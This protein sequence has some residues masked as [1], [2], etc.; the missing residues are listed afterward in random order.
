[1]NDWIVANINNS[2]FTVSDFHDIADMDTNNTQMLS[3]E[4]YLK[5][6]YIKNNPLFQIDGKFSEDLFNKYYQDKLSTFNEFQKGQYPKGPALD[7]FDT[8]RTRDSKVKDIK[9]DI[10]RILANPD[11]QQIGIEGVNIW[12]DPEK[13]KSELAQMSKVFDY[14][15]GEFRDYS[16]ND[17]ALFNGKHDYGIGWLS[18]LFNDPLVMAQYEEDGTHIDP[19]TGQ[20]V[21]HHKGD[22]K[23]NDQGTYYYETLGGRTP[24][25]KRVLSMMDTITI[26]GQGINKYD[27]FDSDDIEKSVPKV[28]AS[29]VVSLLP[30]F[31]GGPVATAYSIGLI[32]KEFSK[33]LPMLYGVV[34]ALGDGQDN[35]K[36]LNS[37]AAI[38]EKF[39][40]GT[41]DYAK[42]HSFSMEN[43]GNMI[44]DV[45]LQW[46]QQKY[47]AKTFNELQNGK[48]YIKEATE[49]AHNL[50]NA[51]KATMGAQ[52]A[53]D[54]ANWMNSNLGKAALKK[55]LPDAEK[56]AV[57][58][59]RLGRDASLAY[60]AI[61]SNTDV[62]NDMLEAGATK[63]EA[64][65]V[66]LGSTIGMFAVD[67]TGL[68]EVFFDDATEE[69]VKQARRVIKNEF[70]EAAK[71]A[72]KEVKKEKTPARKYMRLIKDAAEKSKKVLD[73][74]SEAIKYHS[75]NLSQKMIGEGLEEIAE[76][77]VADTA[78]SIYEI[79]GRLGADTSVKDV[80][81]WQNTLERYSMNF[82]GGALGGGVF[83]G[84]EVWD[85]GTFRVDHNDEELLT[86]IR[87]GH[88][89][90]LRDALNDLKE[91]GK[92]GSTTIS[93][94]D[95]EEDK[96][97][98]KVFITAK[99]REESQNDVLA[100][101]IDDKITALD[102]L[103]NNNQIN[104]DDEELFKR[105]VLGE[106]RF[107]RYQDIS[108]LTN[109]YQDF[110][111][112]MMEVAE[113]SA[114]YN[115]AAHSIDGSVDGKP[116][117]GDQNPLNGEPEEVKIIRANRVK[118]AADKLQRALDKKNAF[119]SGDTSLDY[120]R[121]LAFFMD[122]NLHAPFL[123][124]DDNQ[125]LAEEMGDKTFD[126]YTQDELLDLYGRVQKKKENILKTR[127]TD[128]WE[129]YKAI[130]KMLAPKIAST[131]A[132][133]D[134]H[135]QWHQQMQRILKGG[136]LDINKLIESK[137][138]FNDRMD[139]D[140][141][142]DYEFRETILEGETQEDFKLRKANR[143]MKIDEY[144]DA[145]DK[146][147]VDNL[148]NA[149]SSVDYKIDPLTYDLLFGANPSIDRKTG[150]VIGYAPIITRTKDVMKDKFEKY[151][152][153]HIQVKEALSGLKT[154]L[155]NLQ[156]I[157]KLAQEQENAR[158]NN[159][160]REQLKS[161][162]EDFGDV[163]VLTDFGD[164]VALKDIISAIDGTEVEGSQYDSAPTIG[165]I[166]DGI[167]IPLKVGSID[168]NAT[169]EE[170]AVEQEKVNKNIELANK[171]N[172]FVNNGIL[173]RDFSLKGV[174]ADDN[175]VELNE[176][177]AFDQY[178]QSLF[179][180]IKN[181][182][183]NAV[184]EIKANPFFQL[185]ET[186]KSEVKNPIVELTK[187]LAG[188]VL[189][190]VTLPKVQDILDKLQDDF[191]EVEDVSSITLDDVQLKAFE[192][193]RDALKLVQTYLYAA[194]A[195]PTEIIPIGHNKIFNE[196]AKNHTD[197]VQKWQ[198]LPEV[199]NDYATMYLQ[200]I[201]QY[202]NR[203]QT[204][205]D[206]SNNNAIN[207][208][209]QFIKSDIAFTKSLW[210]SIQ[211][212]GKKAF[213]FNIGDDR[214]NLLEGIDKVPTDQ[215]GK[216]GGAL[217][218]FEAERLLY[219]NFQNA[220]AKSGLS[221]TEFLEESKILD[222]LISTNL[223]DQGIAKINA[224]MQANT[225]SNFDLIKYFAMT[226]ALDPVEFN[227][228]LK[229]RIKNNKNIAPITAQEYG[230]KLIM[231]GREKIFRDI[232][233]YAYKKSGDNRYAALA[234][235]IITGAAGVGKTQVVAKVAKEGLEPNEIIALGPTLKQGKALSES[236]SIANYQTVDA[237][238]KSIL[239]DDVFAN[240]QNAIK[241]D[242]KSDL[243]T[244]K[245]VNGHSRSTINIDSEGDLVRIEEGKA[246][247]K[248]K[249]NKLIN[250]P[251]LLVIDEAT[252]I[253]TP[254]A[255]ILDLYM[256]QNG[257][258]L[259][260][261]GDKKQRGF[262]NDKK[263]VGIGNIEEHNIFA[264]RA[265][266]LDV[267][268][269]DNNIQKQ[270]NLNNVKAIVETINKYYEDPNISEEEYISKMPEIRNLLS[271]LNFKV[272]NKDEIN[273][274]LIVPKLDE[275]TINKIKVKAGNIGYIG[276]KNS[277]T[278]Q[279]LINAGLQDGRDFDQV[280]MEEMQGQEYD[281]V[282][283]D[284]DMTIPKNNDS[285]FR[286]WIQ[287][288][289]T[290]M[291]RGKEA[292]IFIDRGLSAA[293]GANQISEYKAKAPSLNDATGGKS[294]VDVLRENKA[295]LL[296]QFDLS[297]IELIKPKK[298]KVEKALDDEVSIKEDID[299]DPDK[300]GD[301]VDSDG[302]TAKENI[303]E[304][305]NEDI[306]KDATVEELQQS[307]EA[308]MFSVPSF[309]NAMYLSI[310]EEDAEEI[311]TKDDGTEK[312]YKGKKWIIEKPTEGPL[313]N[314]QGL[315]DSDI[316]EAFWYKS[317]TE[318]SKMELQKRLY[319]IRSAA[320][321]EH[322]YEDITKVNPNVADLFTKEAWDSRKVKLEIREAKEMMPIY[323]QMQEIGQDYK[324]HSGENRVMANLVLELKDRN[325]RTVL[326]DL[327]AVNNPQTLNDN[328][329]IILE[330]LRVKKDNATNQEEKSKLT[331]IMTNIAQDGKDYEKIYDQW[332][333]Q[334]DDN[335][336]KPLLIDVGDALDYHKITWFTRRK[337]YGL[338][339]G[340]E[341]DPRFIGHPDLKN[342][343]SSQSFERLHPN[344]VISD[345]YTYASKE[346]LLKDI[347]PSVRGKAVV[348][349]SSDT[350]LSKDEL[351]REY[352][353]QKNHPYEKTPRVRMLVLDNYGMSFSQLM[354]SNAFK[355]SKGDRKP[356]RQNLKGIQMFTSLWNWRAALSKFNK[357]VEKFKSDNEYSNEDIKKI[358]EAAYDVY[359]IENGGGTPDLD[360][361]AA[362]H[363]IKK[364][365]LENLKKFNDETLKDIPIFRLGHIEDDLGFHIQQFDVGGSTAYGAKLG[366][367][368]K[369]HAQANLVSITPQ[370]A[371]NFYNIVNDIMKA[372]VPGRPSSLE[373]Q[374][375][376]EV[377]KD[378]GTTERVPFGEEEFL[379]FKDAGHRRSLSR[380]LHYDKYNGLTIKDADGNN[381]V[382]TGKDMW[383]FVP[384]FL[385]HIARKFTLL[386]NDYHGRDLE[387][388]NV[389]ALVDGKSEGEV[390]ASL[391]IGKWIGN[392]WIKE[393]K[394]E[395]GKRHYDRT[396]LNMF[397]LMFHGTVENIHGFKIK[398]TLDEDNNPIEELELGT[399]GKPIKTK[400]QK[401]TGVMFKDGFF[402]DPDA[403]RKL[404][405]SGT[406]YD[407]IPIRD[408]DKKI[409]FMRIG[410]NKA[411]F[412]LNVEP[413]ASGIAMK[414]EKL[415]ELFLNSASPKTI[416]ETSETD[417]TNPKETEEEKFIK[418]HSATTVEIMQR[419][420][421]RTDLPIITAN[422]N[423]AVDYY[424]HLFGSTVQS[425]AA[426]IAEDGF[427]TIVY[428]EETPNHDIIPYTMQQYLE[429]ALKLDI[430]STEPCNSTIKDGEIIVNDKYHLVN[431]KL[432]AIESKSDDE[433]L[434][435]II[436]GKK[437]PFF[438][439]EEK[440]IIIDYINDPDNYLFG[441]KNDD[442]IQEL[443]AILNR[444]NGDDNESIKR[445]IKDM[446]DNHK[447]DDVYADLA[448]ILN[449]C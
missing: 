52:A 12:S 71:T 165:D 80:G 18:S 85:K 205:I 258:Q 133:A 79:A 348:F 86:L 73:N 356:I 123:A 407:I 142:E 296:D 62:Y 320:I 13:S 295:R 247:V 27:F 242:G 391:Q 331:N 251:K 78:K 127:G 340:G 121:K 31:I 49:K 194:S 297:P 422:V 401:V 413:R 419:F 270:Y 440:N 442:M 174:V 203:L 405:A 82:L 131:F 201:G 409:L 200:Q 43:I 34:T 259:L 416:V 94:I 59:T 120:S 260:L 154:D 124:I 23:L 198:E 150:N 268:L 231:A 281:Y 278:Y 68:G 239:G 75:T 385:T 20:E 74:F 428:Y 196:F 304:M 433:K 101:L 221:V 156:D 216:E 358:S 41:S 178:K 122:Q 4:S 54:D 371:I 227:Q 17:K 37:I 441:E 19:I 279:Q 389:R 139:F 317:E 76:E 402:I 47:I 183:I 377:R 437:E 276:D 299:N 386:Q 21:T 282:I 406:D 96:D 357:A 397:D 16:P 213:T 308:S 315:I 435:D 446:K 69:S 95:T 161:I 322:S 140:T 341:R 134:K 229:A 116:V 376:K 211:D 181:S 347:D 393:T 128:A 257:G 176:N 230:Q 236:L 147:W 36:W 339:L 162:V 267:S 45:A 148:R 314:L 352:I 412:T 164:S 215:I 430:G 28:I 137:K 449:K 332:L 375:T 313:R 343:F 232:I 58:S 152:S 138:T 219:Q 420:K 100:R 327:A 269:R 432:E 355:T 285:T 106:A 274:D 262:L 7:M 53:I 445:D 302:K 193:T 288:L 158:Q 171:L 417:E 107:N 312:I 342:T 345:V 395:G 323:R 329:Y 353:D 115:A 81:A 248:I 425:I 61:I 111:K 159:K 2:D 255:Q 146:A 301:I 136:A 105:M 92:L 44:A 404:N 14:E 151:L 335:G 382:Y 46:G 238:A 421:E 374:L 272:Y 396:L 241:T 237:F 408:S 423:Q 170:K 26:D 222:S 369:E 9:F 110:N 179:E 426:E 284:Q 228:G 346:N 283:I 344:L 97:G 145:Q 42:E 104:L 197:M 67:R 311:V 208:K 350:L 431:G 289:Y 253:A 220:L 10:G 93:G 333:K 326:I 246:P 204:W 38:G 177:A 298:S 182:I 249:F 363:S 354:H 436:K 55:Y 199:P 153:N 387:F 56:A 265:P 362:T 321:Y 266:E 77:A 261:L 365:D 264:V 114:K 318:T 160:V 167:Y 226:F 225:L 48:N 57:E 1:M 324:E 103:L 390:I 126:D 24:V 305:A 119:L 166:I 207:K 424:N 361:I 60:M 70:K 180:P 6:D 169:K 65:A 185:R 434:E 109:Y 155:S 360:A 40:G 29:N 168:P 25:G 89:N 293:I 202:V 400:V 35:P 99:S 316:L 149:L 217:S 330:H 3:R 113:A 277:A 254:I 359:Q 294:A 368:A 51:K 328:M 243:F 286:P 367:K 307:A 212:K 64:A 33:S 117:T 415:R 310:R 5:S 444:D 163:Q 98:K 186:L 392:G 373:L 429:R 398:H 244:I 309:G 210:D 11:R 411:L 223:A 372:L 252:H 30:M 290:L 287:K 72:F 233:K 8:N 306:S 280:T 384:G 144:N 291:S 414:I 141:D 90:E 336:K 88:I 224:N 184:N 292:S 300:R 338:R 399:D 263:N 235:T 118:E 403:E 209:Q 234:T 84:K 15:T 388:A 380:V 381:L 275:D 135:R 364:E 22:Y 91:K 129:R 189:D 214:Y 190:N 32:A 418:E 245:E 125:L 448:K 157:I 334:Y 173:D 102:A 351:I 438:T 191:E 195:E 240:L 50:Y 394:D 83:Y 319:D 130:E 378:D 63:G 66:A 187:S 303:D 256:Q 143:Q 273:G 366:E 349:I 337:G 439:Q 206:Y 39:T 172:E 410:T 112:I 250:I 271:K 218:L 447:L 427:N 188:E 108:K 192:Q 379:D 132:D 370:K 383:S 443:T 325:G 87:N 175:I